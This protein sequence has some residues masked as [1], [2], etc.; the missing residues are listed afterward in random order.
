MAGL[1]GNTVCDGSTG[2]DRASCM[3]LHIQYS[4]DNASFGTHQDP[5]KRE[6]G[7]SVNVYRPAVY[8][9]EESREEE[10][11]QVHDLFM[12]LAGRE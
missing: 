11:K 6:C 12:L 8:N 3:G 4:R 9:I 7:R 5:G 1:A 2:K 10:L